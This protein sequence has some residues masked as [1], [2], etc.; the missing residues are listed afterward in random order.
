MCRIDGETGRR[1]KLYGPLLEV[2]NEQQN[3]VQQVALYALY[4]LNSQENSS[5]NSEIAGLE[6]LSPQFYESIMEWIKYFLTPRSKKNQRPRVEDMLG[7]ANACT[8][9]PRKW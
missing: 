7:F 3:L 4:L 9:Y 6:Q 5:Y 1:I 8:E 2:L